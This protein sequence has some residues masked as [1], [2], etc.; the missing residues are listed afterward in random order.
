M[1]INSQ[2]KDLIKKK[3]ILR[4]TVISVT[5]REFQCVD[6]VVTIATV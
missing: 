6:L 1:N 5:C 3:Y 4:I 2:V